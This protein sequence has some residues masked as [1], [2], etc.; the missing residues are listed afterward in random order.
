MKSSSVRGAIAFVAVVAVSAPIEAQYGA[1]LPSD[2]VAIAAARQ[3]EEERARTET[4]LHALEEAR[5]RA[6][7]RVRDRV[8]TLYRMTRAGSLPLAGGLPALLAHLGRVER[9]ERMVTNDVGSLAEMRRREGALR[10]TLVR[11]GE[12]DARAVADAARQNAERAA[13]EESAFRQAFAHS[14]YRPTSSWPSNESGFGI[15]LSGSS[16]TTTTFASSRGELALPVENPLSLT[17]STRGAASGLEVQAP[18]GAGVRAAAAGRV[19]FSRRHG[20]YGQLLIVD[21]G[22]NYFTVYGGIGSTDLAVGQDVARGQVMG[23]L[24]TDPMFFEVRRGSR[25]LDARAWLGL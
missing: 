13:E 2:G 23:R 14:T 3:A 18:N 19:V 25:A 4:E 9:L 17:A 11:V 5:T 12:A 15:R 8:R 20:T 24:G 10:D 1:F 6:D 21:H 7:A 22:D 16:P